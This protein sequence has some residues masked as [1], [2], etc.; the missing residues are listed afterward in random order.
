MPLTVTMEMLAEGGALLA[1]GKLLVGMRD[2]RASRWI[3]LEKPDY[4]IEATAKQT[5]PGEIHVALREAG[6]ADYAASHPGGSRRGIRRHAIPI[7]DRPGHSCS[8]TKSASAWISDQLYRTGMFHGYM[9]QGTKSVERA[10]RNGSQRH[11]R[12]PAARTL[13][14]PAI[15]G[16]HFYSIPCCWMPPDKWSPTGFGKPSRKARICSPIAW[17]G[18]IAMRRP[19]CRHAA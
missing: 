9:M 17:A 15:R 6:A 4:T 1:S 18:F 2:I 5:A 3:T 12:S 16:L 7:P 11:A 14:S 13:C 19:A 8:K 10:G